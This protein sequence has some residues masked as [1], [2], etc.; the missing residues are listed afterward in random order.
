M[1]Y[2]SSWG[3]TS[4]STCTATGLFQPTNGSD[5]STVKTSTI[6]VT[7]TNFAE[8]AAGTDLTFTCDY[9]TGPN[10]VN[11]KQ[12]MI[13]TLYTY[14]D[15]SNIINEWCSSDPDV[16]VDAGITSKGVSSEWT[17]SI[18]PPNVN[19]SNCNGNLKFKLSQ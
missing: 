11:S 16:R 5:I 18:S 7:I 12:E 17:A 19:E 15:E 10:V 9:L 8:I 2:N 13:S 3:I 1:T 6:V 14:D 4:L